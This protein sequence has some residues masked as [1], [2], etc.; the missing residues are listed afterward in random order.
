MKNILD[1]IKLGL[2]WVFCTNIGRL[3][4]L[5]VLVPFFGYLSSVTV[6][7]DLSAALNDAS[8]VCAGILLLYVLV[9]IVFAWIINPI[10]DYRAMKQAQKDAKNNTTNP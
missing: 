4:L 7:L 9:F 2:L 10:K 8:M 5:F 6:N 1:K 3:L